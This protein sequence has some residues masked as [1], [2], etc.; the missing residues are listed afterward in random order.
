MNSIASSQ[1]I[2][3]ID[4]DS[5]T[6]G[7]SLTVMITGQNTDFSQVSSTANI[8]FSRENS[9]IN[10]IDRARIINDIKIEANFYIPFETSPGI[11]DVIVQSSSHPN[12]TLENGM[13]ILRST[14]PRITSITPNKAEQGD[15]LTVSISG[16]NTNFAQGSGTTGILLL[17]VS[18]S[19]RSYLFG[20]FN[21]SLLTAEFDIPLNANLGLWDLIVQ[22]DTDGSMTL[23]NAFEIIEP[24]PRILFI[25]PDS[26]FQGQS[27]TL[28]ITSKFTNFTQERGITDLWLGHGAG[29]IF[30]SSYFVINDT[31]LNANFT[32]PP[33]ARADPD[34]FNWSIFIIDDVD[35]IVVS[36]TGFLIYASNNPFIRYVIP[37]TAR[38]GDSLTIEISGR[39]TQF[40]QPSLS[41]VMLSRD[42]IQIYARRYIPLESDTLLSADFEIPSDAPT[43]LWNL[44]FEH[45]AYG[46][47]T[48]LDAFDIGPMIVGINSEVFQSLPAKFELTENYPNPFNPVTKISYT[49]P[50][51]SEV[52]LIIY[53][54]LGDEVARLVDGFQQAGEYN[55]TWNASNIA[56]GI[57]F[58][59]LKAG[60]FVQTRKMVLLK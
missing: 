44:S 37:D 2:S 10:S 52:S 6:Q 55:T 5:T 54:I 53:N 22:N 27:L 49:L 36:T 11:W 23:K 45:S 1:S 56:S 35:G 50:I 29:N 32:I 58:Y 41:L 48:L 34:K 14:I 7:D 20:D 9:I 38:Q 51:S 40:R 26:A 42:E 12:L 46:T 43:G 21:D 59:R 8:W 31:S 18:S 39:N 60:D 4:P 25:V 3:A 28:Q 33:D 16:I 30:P 13:T 57:Y 19:I 17:Q 15:T 24:Q 47:L